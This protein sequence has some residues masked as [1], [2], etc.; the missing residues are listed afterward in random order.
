MPIITIIQRNRAALWGGHPVHKVDPL[1]TKVCA[2]TYATCGI[3]I[4]YRLLTI[5]RF[6]G[7]VPCARAS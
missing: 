5:F 7:Y 2:I 3:S 4:Q 1:R 6:A